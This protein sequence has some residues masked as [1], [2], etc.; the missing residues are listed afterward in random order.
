MLHNLASAY[1][2]RR[3]RLLFPLLALTIL[4]GCTNV[5]DKGPAGAYQK[6]LFARMDVVWKRLASERADQMTD[7]RVKIS[8]DIHPDGHIEHLKITSNTGSKILAEVATRTVRETR[9]LP[10]PPG[11]VATLPARRLAVELTFVTTE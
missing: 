10:L 5:T 8:F 6:E 4:V 11:V 7:A 9:I 3:W 2:V 1:I